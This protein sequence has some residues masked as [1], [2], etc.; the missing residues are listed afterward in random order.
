MEFPDV[1]F[2]FLGSRPGRVDPG[3][4]EEALYG[5]SLPR[6]VP[7]TKDVPFLRADYRTIPSILL[8]VREVAAR[9]SSMRR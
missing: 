2:S 6:E 7:I 3:F 5:G 8:G 1:C 4:A 9:S